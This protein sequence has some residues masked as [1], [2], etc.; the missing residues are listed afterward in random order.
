MTLLNY[1][2][3]GGNNTQYTNYTYMSGLQ[4]KLS[5]SKQHKH[6]PLFLLLGKHFY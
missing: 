5:N 1:L 6:G 3:N 2:V 4:I